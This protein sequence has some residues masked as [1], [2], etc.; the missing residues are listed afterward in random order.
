MEMSPLHIVI[1]V[2]V[3]LKFLIFVGLML[4]EFHV[5][6]FKIHNRSGID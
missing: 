2:Y 5:W 1:L 3:L 6:Y 4:R